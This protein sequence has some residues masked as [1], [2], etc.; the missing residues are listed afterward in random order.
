MKSPLSHLKVI[1]DRFFTTPGA[2]DIS[3]SIPREG[4]E[5]ELSEI[6]VGTEFANA[7]V[8]IKPVM[9]MKERSFKFIKKRI[10]RNEIRNYIQDTSQ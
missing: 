6:F 7:Q 2:G 8:A 3:I 4:E 5:L 1:S 10:I 9:N